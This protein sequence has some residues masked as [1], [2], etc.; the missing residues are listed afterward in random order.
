MRIKSIGDLPAFPMPAHPGDHIDEI[1]VRSEDGMSYRQW[2][3][4]HL[5]SGLA[6]NPQIN[7]TR[8]VDLAFQLTDEIID[9]LEMC[10][11][12]DN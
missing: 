3:V 9:R 10:E 4:A 7:A 5:A 11:H 6:A 1:M 12:P 8:L 2:L